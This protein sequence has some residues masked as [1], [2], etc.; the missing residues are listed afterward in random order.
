MLKL[1]TP[2]MH[3]AAVKRLQ[4]QLG[5]LAIEVDI[6]GIYGKNTEDAVKMLQQ[7]TGMRQ[8]GVF[9]PKTKRALE[10]VIDAKYRS[11]ILHDKFELI[12][13]SKNHKLP[14]LADGTRPFSKIDGVTMH[15]TG[16]EMPKEPMGWSR[17]NAH[18]GLTQ[19][20][21]PILINEPEI[22]IW[23]AQGLS[24]RSIGVEIEGNFPGIEGNVKTLWKGGGGPHSLSKDMIQGSL[25]IKDDIERRF[26]E[27][28]Q[29][30][31]YIF[32]HRQSHATKMA[33]PGQEIWL[34]IALN[35]AELT[36]CKAQ[37]EFKTKKGLPLPQQWGPYESSYW[38]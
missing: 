6:D 33:D 23:H 22:F 34:K 24:M 29:R 11:V 28:N 15:Q 5:I 7:L 25:T 19:E 10:Q 9:G 27:Q 17:V 16:C 4:E 20:G 30:W 1:T 32:A 37:P 18:Y 38:F 35:W 13:I 31:K 26:K 8:D 14:R 21:R 36:G 3:G 12:D 2:M